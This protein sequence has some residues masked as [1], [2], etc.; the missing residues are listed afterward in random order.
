[1][2]KAVCGG[3]VA[4]LL[5]TGMIAGSNMAQ[6]EAGP[7]SSIHQ[8]QAYD[9]DGNLVKLDKYR[10]QAAL[11]VNV[12]SAWGLTATNYKQLVELHEKYR[13][14]LAVLAFPC[15]QF[16][17]QEP[18]SNEDIKNF[19]KKYNVQ[20]DLFSKI[21]VNGKDEDP[22]WK[23]LKSKQGGIMGDAIKWNFTKFLADAEG[24]PIARYSPK[25]NP[26]P[27]I[28]KDIKKLVE[29]MQ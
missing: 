28:E 10:G 13:P 18:G 25:T 27:K 9:I 22:L 17:S 14:H 29:Q 23:F 2:N 5:T 24:V 8:F 6:G 1:M 15:N 12:A 20:F 7:L 16:G 3:I 19:A 26:I 21:K 4:G 11:I